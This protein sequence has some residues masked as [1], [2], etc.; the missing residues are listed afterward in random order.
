MPY[1]QI[2]RV[3]LANLTQMDVID[4]NDGSSLDSFTMGFI[5]KGGSHAYLVQ[6]WRDSGKGR[7]DGSV[8][9]FSLTNFTRANSTCAKGGPAKN[10]G[11]VAVTK[12]AG[13]RAR[14]Y[15]PNLR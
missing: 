7:F 6:A 3:N 8:V 10:H 5:P 11:E 15:V 4:F 1:T 12:L 13:P 14:G 2:L 9:R